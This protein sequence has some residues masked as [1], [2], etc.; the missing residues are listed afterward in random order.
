MR[1]DYWLIHSLIILYVSGL[2]VNNTNRA[3]IPAPKLTRGTEVK[4]FSL[5]WIAS[6]QLFAKH[7]CTGVIIDDTTM[8]TGAHCAHPSTK[9]MLE[10]Q[11][12]RHILPK[13]PIVEEAIIF[14]V[15]SITN[16]PSFHASVLASHYNHDISIWKIEWISG[17]LRK[18]PMNFI[19]FDNG[20]LSAE[21]T[22]LVSAGWGSTGSE[23]QRVTNSLMQTRLTVTSYEECAALH[24]INH[25]SFCAHS[26]GTINTCEEGSGSPLL[27]KRRRG[28]FVLVAIK[29]Y[30]RLNCRSS[31]SIPEVFTKISDHLGWII[32]TLT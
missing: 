25:G 20:F 2:N 28:K 5:P 15:I 30:Q 13:G 31:S 10:V 7:L 19:E 1:L 24:D 14:K 27:A 4:P 29:S 3:Q 18:L 11:A 32:Q 17:D 9:N 21:N 8:I 12:H 23:G 26:P 16:H 6:I 22:T